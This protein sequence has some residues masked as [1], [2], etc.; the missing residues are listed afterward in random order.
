M[1]R[2]CPR[3][4]TP[5]VGCAGSSS[6]CLPPRCAMVGSTR[7]G[8]YKATIDGTTVRAVA[9]LPRDR[10]EEG[11][12]YTEELHMSPRLLRLLA[13]PFAVAVVVLAGLLA[14]L[15]IPLA[16]RLA[17]LG[18]M[19]LE[20]AVGTLLL[21]SLSR[22]RI[23]IDDGALTIAFRLF[24]TKR[25]PLGRIVSCVPSDARVWGMSYRRPGMRYRGHAGARRAG[26]LSLTNGAQVLV[27][28]HHPDAACAALRARRPEIG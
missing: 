23:A 27:T 26:M 19:L 8:A 2:E 13:L 21:V 6:W 7:V 14:F 10:R 28:S 11:R 18:A 3:R 5:M 1:P 20:A 25:I 15:P 24:F 22:I 4:A 16:G 9:F 12:M 17:I